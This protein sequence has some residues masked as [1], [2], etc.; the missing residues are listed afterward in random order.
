MKRKLI[1]LLVCAV[2]SIGCL[3]HADIPGVSMNR[4]FSANLLKNSDFSRVKADGQPENWYFANMSKSPD[5]RYS[6]VK[7]QGANCI[8]VISPGQKY[9]YYTQP[10]PVTA[11]VRYYVGAK[12]R[13]R[14]TNALIWLECQEYQDGG[15]SMGHYPPSKTRIFLRANPEQGADMKKI[16]DDFIPPELVSGVSADNWT[17]CYG[18]ITP[19]KGKGVKSYL[20]QLGAFGGNAGFV[21]YTDVVFA[22]AESILKISVTNQGWKEY[23]VTG[24]NGERHSG[25]L[26]PDLSGQNVQIKLSSRLTDYRLEMVNSDNKRFVMEV[27]NE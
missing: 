14:G 13:I 24:S 9:G 7:Y 1:P 22:P 11:G 8:Q 3:C 16:L 2:C 18:E 20:I 23:L 10:V 12:I 26:N 27:P 25:K 21:A 5:F 17:G 15:S 4:S 19:P 6:V